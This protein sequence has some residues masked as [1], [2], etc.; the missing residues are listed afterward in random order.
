VEI[1]SPPKER[2]DIKSYRADTETAIM[3][4]I[5]RRPCTADD[6]A[7]ILGSHISEVNKYLDVL[8]AEGVIETVRQKRGVFYKRKQALSF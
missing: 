6:I 5:F 3:E 4:T 2:K 1:I 8:E 7:R